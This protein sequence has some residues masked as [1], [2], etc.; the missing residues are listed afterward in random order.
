MAERD[1][2]FLE[3]YERHRV[4]GQT[5]YYRGKS[6]WHDS[7]AKILV[8]A[9]GLG[10]FVAS[11]SAVM[12]W[13][14]VASVLPAVSGALVAVG[15]LYEFERNHSRFRNTY[16]DLRKV[17]VELRP[18]RDLEGQDLRNALVGYVTEVEDLLSREHRQWL[19]LMTPAEPA[20]GDEDPAA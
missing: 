6:A 2:E 9:A 13:H 18:S 14:V 15:G 7:R 8:V 5:E 11:L 1:R 20:Q 12:G 19:K 4:G 17:S 3:Y 10:M 16:Y